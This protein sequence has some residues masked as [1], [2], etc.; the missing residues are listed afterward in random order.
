MED[1]QTVMDSIGSERAVICG[2]S[3][4]GCMSAVFA[5]TY[6]DRA[7]GLIMI[8]TYARRLWAP[9]Y[10]WAPHPNSG[11]RSSKRSVTNGADR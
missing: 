6:P 5:A 1:V 9:D 8:G 7:A 10:P 3:E 4:G 11:R 2:V